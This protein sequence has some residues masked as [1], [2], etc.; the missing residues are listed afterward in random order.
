M[1]AFTYHFTYEFRTGIR[2]KML[3][4]MNYL[5]PLGF[6]LMMG[7]I[8]PEINPPFR[9]T[10]VPAMV[11]FAILAA[12]LL[13]VPDP[14]VNAR[15]TGIFRSYKING[16]PATSILLIPALTT[17]VHLVLVTAVITITAP[18][19]FDAPLPTNGLIYILIIAATALAC[20]GFSVLIGVVS[21]STRM[22]VLFVQLLFLPSML[23]GGLMMP[24]ELLPEA[25]QKFA[26]LLPATHAMN[27]LNGLVMEAGTAV[28]SP[29]GSIIALAVSG[30]VAFALALYLFRW[31]SHHAPRQKYNI[32]ALLA[33]AP[34][35]IGIFL[36]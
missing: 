18:I 13:G 33:F 9:E 10:L 12:T 23:L 7:F 16:I 5:F 32:L 34:Y 4:M 26:Q 35:A 22:T 28:F 6:Y 1:N 24:F 15:E 20:T 27:A 14:L 29:W 11:T 25:A 31:D 30:I 19:L 8:M 36:F 2:N 17:M 3:L 21:P